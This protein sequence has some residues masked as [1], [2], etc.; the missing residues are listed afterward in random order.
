MNRCARHVASQIACVAVVAISS[1]GLAGC[2]SHAPAGA[3]DSTV[4]VNERDFKISATRRV[5]SGSVRFLVHNGGPD[6]HELIVVRTSS[7]KLPLRRDGETVDEEALHK[8]TPGTLEPGQ[9]GSRRSLKLH[10]PPGRYELI[11]NMSGHYL[12]GMHAA[13]VVQ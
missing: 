6:A 8:A 10:L 4:Q 5:R 1:L 2:S 13:L 3:A 7:A 11:C 12:G 9:P